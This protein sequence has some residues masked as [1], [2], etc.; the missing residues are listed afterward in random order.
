ME[1]QV[2]YFAIS[3]SIGVPALASLFNF[4]VERPHLGTV[5][6]LLGASRE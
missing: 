2:Y 6:A 1:T 5:I 3:R 4:Q